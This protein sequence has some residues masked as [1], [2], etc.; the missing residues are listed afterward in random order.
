MVV[1]LS[2]DESALD[3]SGRKYM[4]SGFQ[5]R[6]SMTCKCEAHKKIEL[7]ENRKMTV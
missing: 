7:M 5:Q 4:V 3:W 1:V 2:K 6:L